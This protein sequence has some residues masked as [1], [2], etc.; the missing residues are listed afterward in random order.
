MYLSLITSRDGLFCIF[1]RDL[2]LEILVLVYKN[3]IFYHYNTILIPLSVSTGQSRLL[4]ETQNFF[5]CLRKPTVTTGLATS[6]YRRI[7]MTSKQRRRGIRHIA[8]RLTRRQST[9]A[10]TSVKKIREEPEITRP[11]TPYIESFSES[12]P[13]KSSHPD[14]RDVL[15][16]KP[17]YLNTDSFSVHETLPLSELPPR[18]S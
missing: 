7:V 9:A 16:Y 3:H 2:C 6:P 4:L 5:A 8:R 13:N 18:F 14:I 15:F 10:T 11:H 12:L 1:V 17:V